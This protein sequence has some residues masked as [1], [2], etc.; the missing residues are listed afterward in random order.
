[1]RIILLTGMLSGAM[2][3]QN[4]TTDPPPIVQIV[5]KP[6]TAGAS[7]RPNANAQAAVNV[8]G[9][10]SITGV[11]ETWLVEAHYSWA[12]VEDLDQRLNGLAPV[13]V[14]NDAADPLQDDVIAPARTMIG[15]YRPNWSYRPVE[16]VRLFAK[17]RYF[18]VSV[19][20]I[21]PGTEA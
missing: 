17:A 13:R 9:M 15:L 21:R 16:A 20:R 10:R 19:F 12:S 14:T 8:L 7:M 5:R 4:L 2:L 11:P 3:G 18:Q 1:M 6:G